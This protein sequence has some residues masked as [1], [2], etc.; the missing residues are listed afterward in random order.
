MD[1]KDYYKIL[2]VDKNA[3]QEEI[4]IAYRKLA[5]KYHP[6]KNSGNKSA[7]EK[8]KEITEAN[9]V[10]SDPQKRSQYDK[11]GANWKNVNQSAGQ[12]HRQRKY[13]YNNDGDDYFNGGGFSDFFESFFGRGGSYDFGE[14]TGSRD[15][16]GEI[17]ISLHEAYHGT[18]RIVTIGE[19]KIK[20]K[21]KP[22]SYDG[23][24][25]KVKGK[26]QKS[27]NGKAGDLYLTIHV[28]KEPGYE[29]TGRDI[30][31]DAPLDLFT[32][33]LGGKQEVMT[34]SGKVAVTIAEGTDNGKTVR[35]KGKG[36]PSYSG[37]SDAGDL[38]VK[39]T[40]Q[41]PKNLNAAQKELIRKLKSTI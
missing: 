11:L 4:K 15:L 24:K 33:L 8:F 19:D 29:V 35:L 27:A 34:L 21:I 36:L 32:A 20:V 23:L 37:D 1:F 3:T 16:A 9:E 14:Q 12:E 6:D 5:V 26:G 39:F 38:Y 30:F 2:G 7:E 13:Q 17:P 22:G 18:E 40:V 41:L 28:E 10:L 31:M 25:L